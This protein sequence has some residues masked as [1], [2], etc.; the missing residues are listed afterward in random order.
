MEEV[1]HNSNVFIG[2]MIAATFV[3]IMVGMIF[4]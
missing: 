4:G 3:L 2:S 1:K